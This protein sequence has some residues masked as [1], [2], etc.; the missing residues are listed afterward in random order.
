LTVHEEEV[1]GKAYDA[2]LM[3]RLLEYLRP[4]WASVAVAFVAIT[5]GSAASLAQPYLMK[6]AIDRYIAAGRLGDLDRLAI[7][8]L[9]ILIVAFA[10]EYV[11]TWTMQLTGQRVMFDLRMSIYGH[12]QRLDLKY[13]DKNPVG[14]L[15]T[16]VTSDVD[17][18]NDLFTA[19]V[20]TIFG[21]VFA[22]A[23]IMIIMIG[24]NWQLALVAFSVLPLIVLVTQWFRRNV[25]ESYR[26]VRGLIARINAFLQENITGMATV[27]LFRRE[28]LNFAKFDEIDA[29]HRDANISSIFYY[30]VFYPA[31]EAISSLASALII[32]YGGGRVM[33]NALTLGALV[34]FLQYSQRF[35]RPIS[36]MSDKFNVLQSAMAS[37]ERIFKLLDEP[38]GVKTPD[39]PV[40]RPPLVGHIV[41]DHVWFAYTDEEYVIQDVSFEVQPGQRVGIVGATGSGKTTLINLLLRFYDVKRGRIL[42][43][44]I[45]IRELDLADLRGLFSLVLQDVHLFSGTIADNIRLGHAIDDDRL[46]RA[47]RAVHAEPFVLRLPNGYQSAVAERGST[48]SVGQKQLLSFARALAFDPRVLILDEATSSVDTETELIIR[49]ALH[50]LMA[51]RTTIAIAHRLSTIQ[52]M[53]K[54]LV[55]HK[56]KLRESGTHQE[57]LAHRGIYFKLFELQY[58]SEGKIEKLE[59][60]S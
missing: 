7:L 40:K 31:I 8:Y 6:V 9:V 33:Q 45:D 51:G 29:K 46:Q 5:A 21:D 10:A 1:L 2:R 54:I 15:M 23:G 42:V 41:F 48:L 36:D 39:R 3:R 60:R 17:A 13:Y 35:F 59:V 50:V 11:Q 49:D 19:G 27:Q 47:A 57:L 30:A 34:A 53:D 28:G 43:D 12:L 32:W 24:M 20:I 26:V 16:R 22:L 14:R 38:V 52:D 55:L 37:S 58:K 25:R 4:Y 44:G 56:G 18:L